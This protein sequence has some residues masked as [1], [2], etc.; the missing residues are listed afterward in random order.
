LQIQSSKTVGAIVRLLVECN[1]SCVS[2][3][4]IP[5]MSIVFSVVA[6]ANPVFVADGALLS[7]QAGNANMIVV[8]THATKKYDLCPN[9]AWKAIRIFNNSG[10][11]IALPKATQAEWESLLTASNLPATIT[12]TQTCCSNTVIYTGAAA[13]TV[14]PACTRL[15]AYAWGAGGGGGG[16]ASTDGTSGGFSYARYE[17]LTPGVTG[18]VV[19]P[20]G[21]AT[22]TAGGAAGSGGAGGDGGGAGGVGDANSG[23]VGANGALT[24]P[25]ITAAY[26]NAGTAGAAGGTAGGTGGTGKYG[27][28]GGGAG[29]AG[30]GTFPG[31]GTNGGGGGGSAKVYTGA[32]LMQVASGGGGGGELYPV[33]S[34]S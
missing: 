12:A 11:T 17:G 18:G 28:G 5:F 10:S 8:P 26:T 19:T 2:H 6:K 29:G 20:T 30:S 23:N 25:S 3:I 7:T 27:G 34:T 1:L 33:F 13:V 9:S 21:G 4:L 22:S 16:A 32:T 15:L 24:A 31:N 14:P